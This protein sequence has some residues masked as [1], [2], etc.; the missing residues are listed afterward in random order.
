[1]IFPR[2]TILKISIKY[3]KRF[4]FPHLRSL[5]DIAVEC[6]L[7]EDCQIIVKMLHIFSDFNQICKAL[8]FNMYGLFVKIVVKFVKWNTPCAEGWSKWRCT[9]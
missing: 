3:K 7:Y 4:P 9:C 5:F 8:S 2:Y 6:Q 1:M